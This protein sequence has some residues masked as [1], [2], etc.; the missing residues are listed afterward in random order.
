MKDRDIYKALQETFQS[1][2]L[3]A[4]IKTILYYTMYGLT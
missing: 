3:F 1:Q 2:L 4:N